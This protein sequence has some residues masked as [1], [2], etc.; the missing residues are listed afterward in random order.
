MRLRTMSGYTLGEVADRLNSNRENTWTGPT[1]EIEVQLEGEDPFYGF[2]GIEIPATT[3]GTEALAAFAGIPKPFIMK[4]D[5]DE[6]QY[7]LRTRLER[8]EKPSTMLYWTESGISEARPANEVRV[9]VADLVEQTLR[10]LPEDSVVDTWWSDSQEFRVDVV[11]PDEYSETH[12]HGDKQVGDLTKGGVRIGQDRQ[13]N[14]APWVQ[15]Y[16]LRLV[17]TNGMEV[18]D[19][20]LKVEARKLQADEIVS[21]FGHEVQRAFDRV[22]GDLRS[23]YDLRNQEFAGAGGAVVLKIA[24]EAGLPERTSRELAA[25]YDEE[26]ESNMFNVVNHITERANAIANRRSSSLRNLQ[27]AGGRMVYDHSRRCGECFSRLDTIV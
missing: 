5:P 2:D 16:L 1:Y 7:L 12:I 20:G 3:Q 24:R 4:L 21:L 26:Q 17:C 19:Y 10:V 13:H 23:F 9:D 8:M 6:R 27:T 22:E 14:L 11:V 15:P 25:S 18:P